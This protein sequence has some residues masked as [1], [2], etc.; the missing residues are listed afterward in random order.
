MPLTYAWPTAILGIAA[1][2]AMLSATVADTLQQSS[3][4]QSSYKVGADLR[5]YPVDLG[6]GPETKILQRLRDINGVEGLSLIH[7]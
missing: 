5:V 7:I 2:T 4:D 1:G 3:F 6:S